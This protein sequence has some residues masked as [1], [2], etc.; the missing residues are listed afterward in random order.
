MFSDL[1]DAILIRSPIIP[2]PKAIER[3]YGPPIV[4]VPNQSPVCRDGP[5]FPRRCTDFRNTLVDSDIGINSL[6][7]IERGG[8]GEP[9]R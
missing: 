7:R 6:S 2:R 4:L 9:G 8:D 1:Y 5:T 3:P